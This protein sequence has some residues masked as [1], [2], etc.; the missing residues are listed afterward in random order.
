MNLKQYCPPKPILLGKLTKINESLATITGYLG[1]TVG[2][3]IQEYNILK[4]MDGFSTFQDI[5][6]SYNVDVQKVSKIF[7]RFRNGE[8]KVTLLDEWNQV[9]WCEECETY[10]AGDKC[11]ICGS[12][13]KKIVFSPPCDPWICLDVEQQFILEILRFKFD[14]NLPKDALLLANNGIKNNVFFWEVVYHNKIILKIDFLS[15]N[16]D[17]WKYSLLVNKDEINS[18][19]PLSLNCLAIEKIQKANEER[20]K[21]LFMDSAAFIEETTQM[22]NS[23]PLIYFSSGKESMVIYSLY[24]RLN[25]NANVLT[26]AGGVEFPEDLNFMLKCK[27]MIES[28]DKFD[29]YFYQADGKKIIDTLNEKKLLSAKDPWCRVDFKKELKEKATKDIYK[30]EDF[31]ACEGSRWYENDFRRRHPKIQ[32][33]KDYKYQLWTHPIAEWTYFDVWV[34]LLTQN[35]PINPIYYK[36]FQRTTCWLCPIVNPFH[37]GCS[38]KYYP[39][40]WKQI[41]H[42]R[43]EAFGDDKSKDL[44][45]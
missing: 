43:L 18:L 17:S 45:F 40:L 33:L 44:P 2:L 41:K 29:Y 28:N 42:C 30:G 36:G 8:K 21:K 35:L 5:A 34:Y 3:N 25:I 38:R 11:S 20:Q 10:V 31:L 13:I 19:K 16:E 26:V 9:G 12:D 27:K 7:E 37:L 4:S 14:V 32:Y 39:E 23:K 24:D 6:E 22:Y 1:D 15:M